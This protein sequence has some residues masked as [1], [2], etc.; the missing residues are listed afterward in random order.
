ME[1][2]NRYVSQRNE[3]RERE[4]R[5]MAKRLAAKEAGIGSEDGSSRV[6]GSHS[7]S[8]SDT[9]TQVI[10]DRKS[11]PTDPAEL[12]PA[13]I[14]PAQHQLSFIATCTGSEEF[15]AERGGAEKVQG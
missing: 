1:P 8:D 12:S 14:S 7:M 5:E 4:Q 15:V 9:Y 2:D 6:S 3:R 11:R 13:W 10:K